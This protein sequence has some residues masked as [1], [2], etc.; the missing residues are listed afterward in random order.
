MLSNI[1]F[2]SQVTTEC[3]LHDQTTTFFFFKTHLSPVS[4]V[5]ISVHPGHMLNPGVIKGG[6]AVFCTVPSRPIFLCHLFLVRVAMKPIQGTATNRQG[7]LLRH[8]RKVENLEEIHADMGIHAKTGS[9]SPE[10]RINLGTMELWGTRSRL[11]FCE[12]NCRFILF[13]TEKTDEHTGFCDCIS[14]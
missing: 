9:S 6:R 11:Q 7:M 5:L 8:E 10:L 12:L 2:V 3:G 13:Y 1:C 4:S 14:S